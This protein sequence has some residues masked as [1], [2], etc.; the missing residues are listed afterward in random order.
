MVDTQRAFKRSDRDLQL[1]STRGRRKHGLW[2][3]FSSGPADLPAPLSGLALR[4]PIIPTHVV[5]ILNDPCVC[6]L[7]LRPGTVLEIIDH[8]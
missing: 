3:S 6:F 7:A 1:H 4:H 2:R 8:L 5:Q